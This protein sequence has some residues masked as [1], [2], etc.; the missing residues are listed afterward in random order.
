MKQFAKEATSPEDTLNLFVARRMRIPY[1]NVI[2]TIWSMIRHL[3]DFC[4][5]IFTNMG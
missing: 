2:R 3:L 4:E 1:A 5:G